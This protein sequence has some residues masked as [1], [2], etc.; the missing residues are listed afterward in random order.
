MI[1]DDHD[2]LE[3]SMTASDCAPTQ[4][5]KAHGTNQQQKAHG[6]TQQQKAHGT[7]VL[8]LDKFNMM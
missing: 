1:L 6:T 4:Q 3:S 2:Q 5:Q 7:T 8:L